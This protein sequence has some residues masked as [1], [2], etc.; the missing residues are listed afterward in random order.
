MGVAIN[1]KLIR[2]RTKMLFIDAMVY[3]D[4]LLTMFVL[5]KGIFRQ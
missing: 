5:I 3:I 4:D 2:G 1:E